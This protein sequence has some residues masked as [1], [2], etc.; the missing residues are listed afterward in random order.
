MAGLSRV[1][2]EERFKCPCDWPDKITPGTTPPLWLSQPS[3]L[4]AK[5]STFPIPPTL[6]IIS[7]KQTWHQK[8]VPISS[9]PP[10]AVPS[11]T[12]PTNT[13]K[14][15]E[16]SS[17]SAE[18]MRT[19]P[20]LSLSFLCIDCSLMKSDHIAELGNQRPSKPFFF[21]KPSSS[22]V[23]P[24]FFSK[25]SGR[26]E[27]G[28]LP[29][30]IPAGVNVHYEVELAIIM[31]HPWGAPYSKRPDWIPNSEGQDTWESAIQGYAIG[32]FHCNR[33]LSR[34]SEKG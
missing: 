30:L 4:A 9:E 2:K 14:A 26:H 33:V 17:Q 23:P 27:P 24:F 28:K 1:S 13:G 8:L 19:P 31:A 16:K 34:S 25:E 22:I 6:I 21:L 29:M 11:T 12:L 18:T 7:N 32:M 20:P 5:F 15:P 10:S 3:N